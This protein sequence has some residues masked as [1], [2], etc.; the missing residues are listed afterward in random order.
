MEDEDRLKCTLFTNRNIFTFV[1][2]KELR[3]RNFK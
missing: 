2:W 3:L 1:F